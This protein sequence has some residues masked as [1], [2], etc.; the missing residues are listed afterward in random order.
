MEPRQK[1][2]DPIMERTK[3]LVV[4]IKG[5]WDFEVRFSVSKRRKVGSTLL[6]LAAEAVAQQVWREEDLDTKKLEVADTLRDD[7]LGYFNDAEWVRKHWPSSSWSPATSSTSEV[8]KVAEHVTELVNHSPGEL[9]GIL[10]QEVGRSREMRMEFVEGVWREREVELNV[11]DARERM[12]P[13]DRCEVPHQQALA[14]W[15][16]GVQCIC[17]IL[18]LM[19]LG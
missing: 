15:A 18:A 14:Y 4:F 17:E 13:E 9:V 5:Q 11:G 6:E 16:L 2:L 1:S 12:L 3:S 7:L 19:Y 10:E 8:V